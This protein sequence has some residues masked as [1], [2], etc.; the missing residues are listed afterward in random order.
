MNFKRLKI[1]E[2][3]KMS[4]AHLIQ[5]A[6]EVLMIVAVAICFI[7]EPALAK[8]EEKQKE[9]VLKAFNDRRKFRGENGVNN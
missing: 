1:K 6:L 9:K 3:I 8:W 4:T 2:V 5:T 7:Y